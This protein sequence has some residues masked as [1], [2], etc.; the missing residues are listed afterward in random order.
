MQLELAASERLA[1]VLLQGLARLQ[2]DVHLGLEEAEG[3]AA[4]LLGAVKRDVGVL[5]QALLVVAVAWGERDAD[6]GADEEIAGPRRG[7]AP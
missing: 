6:A 1:Q 5:Q 7:T 2:L 4:G 3:A